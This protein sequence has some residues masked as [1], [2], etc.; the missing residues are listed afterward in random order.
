MGNV[1]TVNN[2]TQTFKTPESL[3]V[4]F[5][6]V[7]FQVEEGTITAVRGASGCGKTTLLLACG[8]MRAPSSGTVTLAGHDLFGMS[9]AER[10]KYRSRQLGYLFQTL[11]LVEYLD[12]LENVKL[13]P[14]VSDEDARRWLDRL[15]MTE[16]LSHKPEALSHG[17]TPTPSVTPTGRFG[18][19]D[20]TPTGTR[21]LR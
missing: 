6:N 20:R 2:L 21:H 18:Q 1:L 16:R 4:A 13:A 15:G 9:S 19:G 5:S 8:G 17:V 14:G 10:V 12:V 3:L 7:S 11:E